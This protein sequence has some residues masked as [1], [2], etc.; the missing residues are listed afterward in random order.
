MAIDRE[1][2]RLRNGAAFVGPA[3]G[4]ALAR[5]EG[6][7]RPASTAPAAATE[8]PDFDV[9]A[10]RN[11]FAHLI[12]Q[13]GEAMEYMYA[14]LFAANPQFR[15]LFPLAMTAMRESAFRE[16]ARIIWRLD[17]RVATEEA[18]GRLARDHRKF[19]VSARHYGPF[20]DALL[21][22]VEQYAGRAWTAQAGVA[23]RRALDYFAKV[24]AAAEKQ[25]A[26][27]QPAWW[28][29][30]VVQ[31]DRRAETIAVLTIRPDRPLSYQ[32][33]QY[34]W[35]QSPRW[36]RIWRRYSIANA[37]R[38]NGLLDIHVRWVPGGMV[39][40][41]LVNYCNSGDTLTL[42]AARGDLGAAPGSGRDLVCIAGGTGLAPIKA[43][44]ES[45]VAASGHG[46]RREVALYVGAR[47]IKDLYDMR[48]LEALQRAYPPL[49][50]IPVVEKE[51][52]FTGRV[53][54]LPEV[55]AAHP[56]FRDCEVYV[57]GP[58][59]LVSATVRAL[60]GRVPPDRLHHEPVETLRLAS[61][62]LNVDHLSR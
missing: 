46:R 38:G 43:I 4:D 10:V 12:A 27:S 16:L 37:P 60:T 25:D 8:R 61:S 24:M 40:T 52:D 17:D 49:T 6:S 31:H 19:G 58:A 42:G 28:I 15:S 36:P 51:I 62:P 13:P 30:E 56:S 2:D 32:P 33:G 3:V 11:T 29:G 18:L 1:P 41:A 26:Q 22:T 59:G 23:W 45:V 21:A 20:F 53:G 14:R 48:D 35:V 50:L 9:A 7:S 34:I 39:S 57:A 47:R 55:V 54:R 5:T 44:I